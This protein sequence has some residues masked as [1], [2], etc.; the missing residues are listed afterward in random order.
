M[1]T[2]LG[3]CIVRMMVNNI[4]EDKEEIYRILIIKVSRRLTVF[5]YISSTQNN[6]P[7]QK[8]ITW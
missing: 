7:Y 3:N 6:L 5:V 1:D 8:V 4:E 2:K